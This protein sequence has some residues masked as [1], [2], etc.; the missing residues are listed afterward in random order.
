MERFSI[1]NLLELMNAYIIVPTWLPDCLV[2]LINGF[3]GEYKGFAGPH[4][5]PRLNI[6]DRFTGI[7]G[8]SL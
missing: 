3:I 2:Q 7:W 4:Q 5:A 6:K 1:E 8:L